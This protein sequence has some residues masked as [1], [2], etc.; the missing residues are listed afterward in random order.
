MGLYKILPLNTKLLKQS[1]NKT[2]KKKKTKKKIQQ[3]NTER[4]ISI[5]LNSIT[6]REGQKIP[7]Q[8]S[9]KQKNSRVGDHGI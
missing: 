8:T 9:P 3:A 7:H 5:K 2:N 1:T 6:I 4:K